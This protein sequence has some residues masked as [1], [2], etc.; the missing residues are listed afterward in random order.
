MLGVKKT[1]TKFIALFD[2]DMRPH[3][4]CF[5]LIKDL[6]KSKYVGVE[7][8]IKSYSKKLS[9]AINLIKK[10][11]RLILIRKVQEE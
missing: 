5:K 8:T 7:A 10:L 2:A 3:K 6:V 9:Y 1:K 11:W 4:D